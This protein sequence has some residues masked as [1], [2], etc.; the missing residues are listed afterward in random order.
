MEAVKLL[1]GYYIKKNLNKYIE[2][3]SFNFNI[4]FNPKIF[5]KNEIET[6]KHIY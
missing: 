4:P 6:N 1:Y 5:V 3:G 2:D